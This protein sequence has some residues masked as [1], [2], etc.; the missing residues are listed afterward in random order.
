MAR[1]A[2][3]S[4]RSHLR[5]CSLPLRP[6]LGSS[7][8]SCRTKYLLV[9]GGIIQTL[10]VGLQCLWDERSP[11]RD[12][13]GFQVP[14]AVGLGIFFSVPVTAIQANL[15]EVNLALAT[16]TAT[17]LRSLGQIF[18]VTIGGAILQNQFPSH[19]TQ[20][21]HHVAAA[22]AA[23]VSA[24]RRNSSIVGLAGAVQAGLPSGIQ[25]PVRTAFA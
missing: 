7:W 8:P 9:F 5:L 15:S 14:T 16:S 23:A 1:L 20:E 6:S 24:L 11:V 25:L 12:W 18:G 21:L 19:W 4:M 2:P 10:G 3:R 13:M 22:D 17:F